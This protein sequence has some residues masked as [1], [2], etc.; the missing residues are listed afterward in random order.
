MNTQELFDVMTEI[1]TVFLVHPITATIVE[2]RLE[3]VGLDFAI[4]NFARLP[5]DHLFKTY[6]EAEA[7]L[8]PELPKCLDC[9]GDLEVARF[10]GEYY[11]AC[12]QRGSRH[13]TGK[14]CKTK[15]EAIEKYSQLRYR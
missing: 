2:T 11:L 12:A 6:K 8:L 9:K 1:R 10:A 13:V 4:Y 5:H 15:K 7:S 3:A 14:T